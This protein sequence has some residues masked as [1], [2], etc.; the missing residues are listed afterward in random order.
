VKECNGNMVL[1]E[2]LFF[3]VSLPPTQ[4]SIAPA[5]F[6]TCDLSLVSSGLGYN[7]GYTRK[8]GRLET[9]PEKVPEAETG[10]D[11]GAGL[12][13]GVATTFKIGDCV[14]ALSEKLRGIVRLRRVCVCVCC[15]R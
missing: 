8:R 9:A 14:R 12:P 3:P 15:K 10:G 2:P 13:V 5:W 4:S 6:S 11:A 1:V 7:H